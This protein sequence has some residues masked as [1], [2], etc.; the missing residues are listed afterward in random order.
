MRAAAPSPSACRRAV[1]VAAGS[2]D[3]FDLSSEDIDLEFVGGEFV[4]EAFDDADALATALCME[5]QENAKACIEERGAFTFAVPGGSV[6]KSLAG[7]ADMTDGY[8]RI[9]N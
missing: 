2:A 4:V 7:L 6:A 3:D 5:V 1:S 9:I 8:W